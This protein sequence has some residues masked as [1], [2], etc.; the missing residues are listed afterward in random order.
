MQE[1]AAK[2]EIPQKETPT[3]PPEF[4]QCHSEK[5]PDPIQGLW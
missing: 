2:L 5:E 3:L 1:P 4:E